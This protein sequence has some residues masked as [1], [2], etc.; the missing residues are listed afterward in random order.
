MAIKITK[1]LLD[2]AELKDRA[3]EIW[4]TEVKGFHAIVL[5]SGQKT[6]YFRYYDNSRK[7]QRIKIAVFGNVTCDI[8]REIAKSF[9][10]DLAKGIDPK[11]EKEKL[12]EIDKDKVTYVHFF[13]KFTK[14]YRLIHHK[15]STLKVD[16]YIIKLHIM[17]F[18]GGKNIE[19]ITTNDIL[20]FKESLKHV[21]ITCNKCF[22]VIHRSFELAELWGYRQKNSN[23]CRGV[24]KYPERKRER[25]LSKEE[26]RR[27][28][29]VL[30]T[31]EILQLKSPY[32][33]AAIKMLMY[34]GCRMSEILTLKWE[35]AHLV[36]NYIHLKDSKTGE[37]VV[38]LNEPGRKILEKLERREENPYVFCSQKHKDGHLVNIAKAWQKIRKKADLPDVRIHDLR[39][40][41]ASFAIKQGLDLYQV[42]KLLGHKNIRTTTRY[43]HLAREDLIKAS[44]VVGQVFVT[45]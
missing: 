13:E 29:A 8:A 21:P 6:F 43:A 27:L 20:D 1:R 24:K 17:P 4:D 19:E 35:D 30:E 12:K 33:L 41:F 11:R 7:N 32:V 34:T 14:N 15:P 40:S 39:H 23:P 26:L 2:A 22:A 44:N 28:E 5:P 3:Y 31:E 45:A 9:S 16:G 38:P 18:F 25:F 42:A 10:G 36:E 37:R